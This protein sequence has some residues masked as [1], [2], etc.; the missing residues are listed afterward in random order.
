MK[1]KINILKKII[2]EKNNHEGLD[3][4]NFIDLDKNE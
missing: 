4:N 1:K 2:K 3:L